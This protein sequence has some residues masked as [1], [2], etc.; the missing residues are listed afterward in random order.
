MTSIV[1]FSKGNDLKSVASI[2]VNHGDDATDVSSR[3]DS[4]QWITG[5]AL[6]VAGHVNGLEFFFPSPGL[7]PALSCGEGFLV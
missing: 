1:L 4:T 3:D 6:I 5:D 7:G 2:R